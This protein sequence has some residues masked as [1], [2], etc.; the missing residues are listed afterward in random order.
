MRWKHLS[1]ITFVYVWRSEDN[2]EKEVCSL[3]YRVG[4]S[5]HT[6]VVRLGNKCLHPLTEPAHWLILRRLVVMALIVLTKVFFGQTTSF[7][8]SNL[9]TYPLHQLQMFLMF[10]LPFCQ[11][12]QKQWGTAMLQ[13]VY[14]TVFKISSTKSASPQHNSA[15]LRVAGHRQMLQI[16]AWRPNSN[17]VLE[18]SL[19]YFTVCISVG[20][21]IF[22]TPARMAIMLL[23]EF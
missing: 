19:A 21:L 4:P 2:L 17:K 13:P 3:V 8:V 6:Q 7:R 14:Y 11:S 1:C 18:P 9:L 12:G 10:V 23:T 22:Y 20:V 5:S 15:L 16:V